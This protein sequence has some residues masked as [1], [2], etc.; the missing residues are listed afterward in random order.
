MAITNYSEL[1]S[2]IADWLD[3][4]DLT[5]S[6]PDFITLAETRHRRDFK[7]R[8]METRVTANTVAD[9]EYYTLPDNFVA[10]RNIQLNT[11][12]KTALEYLTPEQMDR[13]YAGSN[14]GK[15]KAYSIIGDNI[16]LRPL[17]DSAYEIEMLYYKYFTPLSDSNTT[18]DMLTY[19]PDAYLY[20]ALVEAEP[21][22]QNDKRIQTWAS[23]YE[24]A[25][26]D[27]I[28]SNERDRHSG[29]APTTR[30]DYGLY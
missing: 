28:D 2:A 1:K 15:P 16:Q 8:R 6:I 3:R 5:D 4:T 11:D 12:P 26:K 23:F 19:H 27:I 20:G 24:R 17:P 9:T 7:L 10:M 14:K 18:N 25:K 13:I 29:V 30:I 21:Y 22:L